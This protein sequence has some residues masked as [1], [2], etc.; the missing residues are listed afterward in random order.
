M[1]KHE[2]LNCGHA[3]PAA[4]CSH[5]GQPA[6]THRFTFAA[7]LH[8]IPHS[9]FH[10]DKGLLFTA[11]E[12]ILRP[13][14]SIREY[15]RGKRVQHFRPFGYL[16]LLSAVSAFVAHQRIQLQQKIFHV[17]IKAG[18]AY[19]N[20]SVARFFNHYPA[21]ILCTLIPFIALW[22]WAFNRR[23]GYNYWENFILNT[24]I[25]AQFNLFF[26]A[27]DIYLLI[28]GKVSGIYTYI[29]IAFMAYMVFTYYQFFYT[30]RP[31]TAQFFIHLLMYV[32]I[33][34]TIVTGLSLTG[35]MSPWWGR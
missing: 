33:A 34:L 18:A 30:A 10:V 19:I 29:I 28:S 3:V 27:Y 1:K 8:D 12:L 25:V 21:L 31:G 11:K 24:Y 17:E 14:R 7:V 26:I 20:E 9:V 15:V 2:C 5:C 16:F 4:Y 6:S 23:S 13:G 35:F 32:L 22:S